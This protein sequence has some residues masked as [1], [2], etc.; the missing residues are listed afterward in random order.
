MEEKKLLRKNFIWNILGTGLNAFTSLF[1]LVAVTRINGLEEAGVFSI[2]Y[3]TACILYMIGIYAGRIF[4]VTETNKKISN[5]DF[6]VNRCITCVLMII[7]VLGFVLIKGYSFYKIIIFILVT[8]FKMLEAFS[9]CLYGILQKN[10]KLYKV[11]VSYFI[12]ALLSTIAFI[13][14]DIITKNIIISV[15]SIIVI[16]LVM[17]IL[18]DCRYIKEYIKNEKINKESIAYIFKKG[19]FIFAI[20]FIGIYIV[21]ASKYSID[22]YLSEDMQTIYGIIIMPATVMA[23][24]AQF[25]IHPFINRFKEYNENK[26]YKKILKGTEII[27]LVILGIGI[28]AA[29]CGY[30]IGIPVLELIYGV[31]LGSYRI[32]L[33]FII[34]AATLYNMAIIYQSI[35]VTLRVNISQFILHII[36]AISALILGNI[37]TIKNGIYGAIT[38]YCIVMLIYYVLYNVLEKVLLFKRDKNEKN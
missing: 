38:A 12:K 32:A 16:W 5:K 29:G 7:L 34:L 31:E 19:F 30:L 10:E 14:I 13:V 18:Y 4:Q 25:I 33:A 11:G 20:A 36:V 3:A 22:S 17:I 37:L 6:I 8:L 26:E 9:D 2:A 27:T 1:F 23:L 15:I 21:N 35:L 24:V 28:V